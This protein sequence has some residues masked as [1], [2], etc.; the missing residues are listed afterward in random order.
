MNPVF[1]RSPAEMRA[2]LEENHTRAG[3]L[4]VGF[5]KKATG[6]PTITWPESVD[7]ALCFGW[8]DGVRRN[9]DNRSYTIRFTPR[10]KNSI[11][12]AVNIRKVET[13]SA[14]GRMKPAG[15]AA[16]ASRRE[17]RSGIYSY[18]QRS[19]ELPKPYE[20]ILAKNEAA[21]AFFHAQAPSYRKMVTWHV[22]S[23]KMEETR[24]KRL[25]KLI[26]AWE[27]GCRPF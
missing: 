23:P 26:E 7:E 8:I 11:W 13:L 4:H 1:F 2:W 17:N 6:E 21:R 25:A 9:V 15:L 14:E 3:E 18:E 19:V 27:Q 16:F 12:S 20:D 10:R 22:V 24:L 5:Y